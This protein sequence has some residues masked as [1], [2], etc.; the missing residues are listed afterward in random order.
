[1]DAKEFDPILQKMSEM[2]QAI[3]D[4]RP[5]PAT[6]DFES[7]KDQFQE[8]IDDMVAKQ[9]E[10]KLNST[11]VRRV[12]GAPIAEGGDVYSINPGNKYAGK[13]AKFAKDGYYMVGT[14]KVR[15]VDYVLAHTLLEKAHAMMPDRAEA[16]S[17]DLE[18]AI[19]A[20][21]STGVGTGDELV[22]TG[23]AGQLWE[24]FFLASKVAAL[25]EQVDMPTNPFDWPLGLGDTTWRKGSENT[26]V[27][28]TDLATAKV[29]LTATELVTE[30]NWSYTLQEDAII[31]LMPAYRRR[32]AISGAELI[33][34]FI[35]NA[36]ATDAATG[37]I[38]LD[39]A[40]PDADMYYL[41]DGQ[42]GV[43]HQWL[44]DNTDQT[45]GAGGDALA[46]ADIIDALQKMGKYA[47]TP[48]N[49]AAITD[50]STYLGGF[51]GLTNAV[52]VD[53]FGSDAVVKTGQLAAYRGVPIIVSASHPLAEADGKVSAT[54]ASNTLGT[55]SFVN[56]NMWAVGF[57][58]NLLIEVDRDIRKRQYIMVVSLREAV[59]AHG[60]RSSNTHTAGIVNILV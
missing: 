37:N 38:N 3:V 13:L 45:V 46:D 48:D 54:A 1:M 8:Q 23:M 21:S 35:L 56:T 44:V 10:E 28:A 32:L 51:L 27:T 39:D 60:T 40:D 34:A 9:V 41:S 36:D 15:P 24:D 31:A 4:S 57:R 43:R 53:K 11:P 22:P 14:R 5:D 19:K 16:P 7:V 29:V 26:A 55:I 25:F 2:T 49:V 30:L 59:A 6:F 52:T 17:D 18:S 42:D 20:M 12:P 33:D 47:A 50:V 58:R